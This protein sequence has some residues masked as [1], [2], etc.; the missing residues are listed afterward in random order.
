MKD[1]QSTAPHIVIHGYYGAGNFGDDIILLSMIK[2][3]RAAEPRA[4]ITVLSRDIVPIPAYAQF[5]V[6]SRYDLGVVEKAIKKADL[7]I[8]GGGGI[9][10]DYSGFLLDDHF[11]S[12]TKGLNYYAVPMEMAYLMGKSVMLYAIG[13]GPL[14]GDA[15]KRYLKTVLGWADVITTRDQPSADVIK[16]IAPAAKPVVT[17]D[18]AIGFALPASAAD[19]LPD[20]RKKYCGICL[21]NWLWR[22]DERSRFIRYTADM[23]NHL[24]ER[25]GYTVVLFPFNK[26]KGDS[27]R[28]NEVHQLISNKDAVVLRESV[29]MGEALGILR[30]VKFVIGMRLH[31]AIVSTAN[32]IPAMGIAYDQKVSSY[33]D[34]L[35]MKDCVISLD[36]RSAPKLRVDA[37]V[38][39]LAEVKQRLKSMVPPLK[40]KERQ[41]AKLAI[42][43]LRRGL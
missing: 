16:H 20:A 14:F 36:E 11:G 38:K 13:A 26:G 2:A 10:Q 25:Y 35:D 9:F 18:P 34:L 22:Q 42:K 19:T 15:S 29:S 4:E 3:L 32:L 31:S 21:R 33:F 30:Q 39:N 6:V 8:C 5:H 23:A 37:F 43:L 7:L 12:R 27:L 40:E 24:S 1:T 17:A 41:N 28:I